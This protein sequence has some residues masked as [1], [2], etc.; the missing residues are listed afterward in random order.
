[1]K[2]QTLLCASAALLLFA[3]SAAAHDTG[4]PHKH[5]A[6]KAQTVKPAN[7]KD[8]Y[9]AYWNDPSRAAPPFSYYGGRG[10]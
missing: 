10:F 2:A 6:Q 9:A 4:K 1:M 5:R 7:R 8:P 3:G